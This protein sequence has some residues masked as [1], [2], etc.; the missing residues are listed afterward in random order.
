MSEFSIQLKNE[1]DRLGANIYRF[2]EIKDGISET[3]EI[4]KANRCLNIYSV[5]KVF[6]VTAVGMLYDRGLLRPSDKFSDIFDKN[7][8][9]NGYETWKNTT[10]E[11]ALLHSLGL[12]GGFLDIDVHSR[13]FYGNDYLRTI[14]SEPLI[15]EPGNGYSYT[16]AAFYLLER[17]CEKLGGEPIDILLEKEFFQPLGCKEVAFSKCPMNHPMG[18]TGIYLH[19]EDMAALGQLMLQRGVLNGRRIL[20]EEWVSLVFKKRYEMYNLKG[21]KVFGKGGMYGQML[22]VVPEQ[23]R[24]VAWQAFDTEN[25]TYSLIDFIYNYKE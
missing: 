17:A 10:V 19:S 9:G 7:T 25:K 22:L 12:P 5:A 11:N 21:E 20:S 1:I 24:T 8:F 14:F 23:N 18:G 6:C 3:T 16:D 15:Y 4:I 2:T 13:P